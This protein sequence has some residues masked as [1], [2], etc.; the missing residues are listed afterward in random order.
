MSGVSCGTARAVFRSHTSGNVRVAFGVF[1]YDDALTVTV[2]ADAS[3]CDELA[4]LTDDLQ[5]EL[6][7][8]A[9][10]NRRR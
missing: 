3:L 4:E 5:I 8:V 7:A 9:A 2:V 1:S 6:D 10:T